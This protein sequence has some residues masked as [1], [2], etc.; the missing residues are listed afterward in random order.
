[1]NAK[2]LRLPEKNMQQVTQIPFKTINDNLYNKIADT[3][4]LH[5]AKKIRDE[6]EKYLVTGAFEGDKVGFIH[7][8]LSDWEVF[9][10]AIAELEERLK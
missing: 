3:A 5:T 4:S 7:M 1:M 2:D 9:C 10:S 6:L 8:P